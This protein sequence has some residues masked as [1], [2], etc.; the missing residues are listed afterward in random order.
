MKKIILLNNSSHAILVFR[1]HLIQFLAQHNYQVYC[2]A[3]N[4]TNESKEKVKA[5]GGI[6]VAYSLDRGGL[7]PLKDLASLREL[8]TKFKEISPDIVFSFMA[9]PIVYG[10]IAAKMAKVPKIIAMVEGL[11]NAFTDYPQPRS[12]K[13]KLIKKVQI[14]LYKLSLPKVDTVF[15]LNQDDPKDL[16]EKNHINVKSQVLNGIGLDINEYPYSPPPIEPVSFL[17]IGRLLKEKGISEFLYAA[18]HI[19][20]KYPNTQFNVVGGTDTENPGGITLEKLHYYI[21]AGIINY[22]GYTHSI[23]DWISKSSIFV[24]PSYREGLP[25]ST[26]EAMAMG[27]AVIT[28]NSTGCKETVIDGKNGFLIPKWNV[29]TL[30]EKMEY[31]IQNTH[32]ITPMGIE[33]RKL[34]EQNYDGDIINNIIIKYLE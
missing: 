32:M 18:E 6:P 20:N 21:D 15:F 31:F 33:S 5:I 22:P 24:L 34:A 4:Y 14:F 28:T 10:S 19:K 11:G 16:L 9:K 3:P 23:Q 8:V 29:E 12:L 26:Q 27:R 2:F 17:F 13:M 25:R 30:V 7:N 1:K